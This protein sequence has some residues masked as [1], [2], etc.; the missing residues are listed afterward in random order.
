MAE[1]LSEVELRGMS[2]RA[3]MTGTGNPQGDPG[4][5]VIYGNILRGLL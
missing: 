5:R 3:P 1:G 2:L 4:T